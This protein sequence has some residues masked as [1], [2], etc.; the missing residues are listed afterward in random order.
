M[1]FLSPKLLR[2][3]YFRSIATT[4]IIV[5]LILLSHFLL[6]VY[7]AN[8]FLE[9]ELGAEW[10][11]LIKQLDQAYFYG[12]LSLGFLSFIVIAAIIDL[13]VVMLTARQFRE[14]SMSIIS[15]ANGDLDIRIRESA[16]G[17][18]G[19]LQKS[20]NKMADTIVDNIKRLE[21]SNRLRKELVASVAHDLGGP[22][23]AILGFVDTIRLKADTITRDELLEYTSVSRSNALFLSKLVGELSDLS[24]FDTDSIP[25]TKRCFNI[26]Q[27]IESVITRFRTTSDQRN[28]T[29]LA[30]A[31]PQNP[32]V[33]GDPIMIERVLSNLLEN[34]IH[35]TQAG[36]IITVQCEAK[37]TTLLIAVCDNGVGIPEDDQPFVFERFYRVDKDRSR[38]T[39]GSGLGL[40]IVKKALDLHDSTITLESRPGAGTKII[41]S[42]PI[43]LQPERGEY[44]YQR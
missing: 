27:M 21:D 23:T 3:F 17:P 39:G 20:F 12:F 7:R 30:S 24:R 41:F 26:Y 6:T 19:D 11:P 36:G 34:A 33:L 16:T 37:D 14:V 8:A 42:L 18:M 15:F 31:E 35:Y 5:L 10:Q 44:E 43:V 13:F 22:V 29:I 38:Q 2:S 28:T 25:L 32:M 4:F 40:A 9:K 1:R